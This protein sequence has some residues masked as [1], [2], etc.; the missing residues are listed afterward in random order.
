MTVEGLAQLQKAL[1]VLP[2]EFEANIMRGALRAGVKSLAEEAKLKCPEA[3]PAD[4]GK[5]GGYKGAMRDSIR[6]KTTQAKTGKVRAYVIV[7]G[8]IKGGADVYYSRW[9]EFGTAGH[10]I[11]AGPGKHLGFGGGFYNKVWHPGAQ[12]HPFMRPALDAGAP[13]A[14]DATAI[15]IHNRLM[16]VGIYAPDVTTD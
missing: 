15:Y 11:E 4:S 6:V 8:K 9:V 14:I 7:G 16:T 3:A 12:K 2:A 10:F 1:E 5:Y 13:G